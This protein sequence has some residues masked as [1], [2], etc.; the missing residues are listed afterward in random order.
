GSHGGGLAF[1]PHTEVHAGEEGIWRLPPP[2]QCASLTL[3]R[4]F[5]R[6][7]RHSGLALDGSAQRRHP[8]GFG[9]GIADRI[10]Q[11]RPLS[12]F[13]KNREPALYVQSHRIRLH[14]AQGGVRSRRR[15]EEHT[16]ELQSR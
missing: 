14:L 12:S 15:S 9:A 3:S 8:P 2:Q 4:W 11:D 6:R 7:F 1:P 13:R 16:A 5:L 10:G